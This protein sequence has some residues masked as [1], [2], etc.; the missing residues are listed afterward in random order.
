MRTR[1]RY[2][3]DERR[4]FSIWYSKVF[5]DSNAPEETKHVFSQS[6]ETHWKLQPCNVSAMTSASSQWA[7]KSSMSDP[8]HHFF[9]SQEFKQRFTVS[10]HLMVNWWFG[11]VVAPKWTYFFPRGSGESKPPTHPN[12]QLT[13]SWSHPSEKDYQGSYGSKTSNI[14]GEVIIWCVK[15]PTSVHRSTQIVGTNLM[16]RP[17]VFATIPTVLGAKQIHWKGSTLGWCNFFRDKRPVKSE[18]K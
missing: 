11:L 5:D 9:S 12:H 10:R 8:W 13:I 4:A 1:G 15:T 6:P 14:L 2:S 18:R 16:S 7:Q 3:K 17:E